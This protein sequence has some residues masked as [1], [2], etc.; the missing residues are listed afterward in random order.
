[1]KNITSRNKTTGTT[2]AQSALA[3]I[4]AQIAAL[5]AKKATLAEPMKQRYTELRGELLQLEATVKELDPA[6][7]PEPLKPKAEAKISEL[8]T[9]KGPLTLEEI[10]KELAGVLTNWKL[11]STLKKRSTGPKAIF[12][13]NDGRYSLEAAA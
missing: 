11:K 2:N 6:W 12:A 10:S 1:M 5:N 3:D 4:E 8:L 7:S 13:I 9:A